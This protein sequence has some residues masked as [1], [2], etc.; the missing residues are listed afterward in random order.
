MI[1]YSFQPLIVKYIINRTQKN[2][3]NVSYLFKPNYKNDESDKTLQINE[4]KI[5]WKPETIS[6][7]GKKYI[8]KRL[9]PG[10]PFGTLFDYELYISGNQNPNALVRYGEL[11]RGEGDK[12]NKLVLVR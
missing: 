5:T 3:S 9:K 11:K 12:K 6:F 7:K 10:K 4:T 2:T 8:F 1:Q